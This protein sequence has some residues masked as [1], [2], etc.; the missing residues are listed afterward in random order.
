[1]DC[2]ENEEEGMTVSCRWEETTQRLW[3]MYAVMNAYK[4]ASMFLH[5]F[6]LNTV[7]LEPRIRLQGGWPTMAKEL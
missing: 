1:M 6:R 2:L 5:I 3:Y 7:P 4:H